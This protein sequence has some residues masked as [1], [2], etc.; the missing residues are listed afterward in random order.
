MWLWLQWVIISSGKL[1]FIGI[2][3]VIWL[4]LHTGALLSR[5]LVCESGVFT[6]QLLA[7][8][9]KNDPSFIPAGA[10]AFKRDLPNAILKFVDS[11]HSA[12]ESHHSE[13][14]GCIK[15]FLR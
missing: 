6:H 1:Q 9:S 12:L 10:E 3:C 11:G 5:P 13:I 2:P 7:V 4:F 8:W 15:D 14:A